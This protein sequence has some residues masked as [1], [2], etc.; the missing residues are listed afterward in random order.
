MK[1]LTQLLIEIIPEKPIYTADDPDFIQRELFYTKSVYSAHSALLEFAADILS[2][3]DQIDR[4]QLIKNFFE[5]KSQ[6]SFK[7][8]R[9][10]LENN[11]N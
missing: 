8:I 11:E 1:D 4:D 10:I 6:L 3:P 7:V 2:N 5:M 9:G